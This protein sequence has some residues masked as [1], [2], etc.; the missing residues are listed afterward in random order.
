MDSQR[1]SNQINPSTLAYV[2]LS[3]IPWTNLERKCEMSLEYKE[4]SKRIKAAKD[5]KSLHRLEISCQRIYSA[6]F[7]TPRELV[8]LDTM[9]MDRVAKF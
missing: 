9:L 3:G 1:W 7:L 4:L 5:L 2:L 8:I 6:G